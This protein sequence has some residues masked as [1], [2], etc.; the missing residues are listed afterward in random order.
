MNVYHL[1][2]LSA[3][4]NMIS[5][6]VSPEGRRKLSGT[7]HSDLDQ[8]AVICKLMILIRVEDLSLISCVVLCG[9]SW[10]GR[11]TGCVMQSPEASPHLTLSLRYCRTLSK[12]VAR[13]NNKTQLTENVV[14]YISSS[15]ELLQPTSQVLSSVFNVGCLILALDSH[16]FIFCILCFLV[17]NFYHKWQIMLQVCWMHSRQKLTLWSQQVKDLMFFLVY[18]TPP[19]SQRVAPSNCLYLSMPDLSDVTSNCLYISMPD[20]SD[21]GPPAKGPGLPHRVAE[22]PPPPVRVRIEHG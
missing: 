21:V 15:S 3:D 8:W 16:V 19:N 4:S 10:P 13:T 18:I 20:L 2:G 7:W 14:R 11:Q 5:Y 9:M 17:C 22:A 1:C 6:F 12:W